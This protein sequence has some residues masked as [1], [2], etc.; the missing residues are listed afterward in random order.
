MNSKIVINFFAALLLSLGGGI[1]AAG[2]TIGSQ[3]PEETAM[4]AEKDDSR[5]TA[6]EKEDS[7]VMAT[8]ADTAEDTEKFNKALAGWKEYADK[9]VAQFDGLQEAEAGQ[10]YISEKSPLRLQTLAD[11]E[12]FTTLEQSSEKLLGRW[13]NANFDLDRMTAGDQA[14]FAT[15][16][17]AGIVPTAYEGSPYLRPDRLFFGG[18]VIKKLGPWFRDYLRLEAVQPEDITD[19]EMFAYSFDEMGRWAVQW[20]EYLREHPGN[21][22]DHQS[23]LEAYHNLMDRLLYS[24]M[25]NC[26][27][28]EKD[29]QSQ[30]PGVMPEDWRGALAKIAQE[31]PGTMTSRLINDWLAE[32]AKGNFIEDKEAIERFKK[33]IDESFAKPV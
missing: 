2:L 24:D 14:L 26:P 12:A 8:S 27:A 15:L 18:K 20:E 6:T 10:L 3:F 17:E 29:P 5:G 32:L 19:D 22:P 11:S 7:G 1:L 25:C 4:A 13:F 30:G 28:F 33:L 16:A 31:H 9:A 21:G 23:G